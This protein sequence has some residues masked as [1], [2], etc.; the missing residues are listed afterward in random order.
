VGDR[1]HFR[2]LPHDT[3]GQQEPE[4]KL[5]IV[6]RGAHGDEPAFSR[7]AYF[8]RFLDGDQIT[9][10]RFRTEPRAMA[11]KTG[12]SDFVSPTAAHSCLSITTRA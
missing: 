6:P 8:E 4:A 3:F 12:A 2:T 9:A 10:R 7:N 1:G 5:S 11:T